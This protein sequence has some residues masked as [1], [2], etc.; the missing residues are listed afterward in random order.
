MIGKGNKVRP[1]PLN[2][3]LMLQ[4]AYCFTGIMYNVGSMLALR[5]DQAAW[6]ST[7]AVMG[8]AGMP[9]YGLFVTTGLMKNLIL[10][11]LLMGVSVV[12]LGYGGVITHLLNTGHMELYQSVW[13]WVGAIGING[14]GLALNLAAALGWFTRTS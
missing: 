3:L 11:R 5:N 9:L 7:D 2:R 14:F 4:L 1:L 10:Y 8:V 6:A 13:T 12:L